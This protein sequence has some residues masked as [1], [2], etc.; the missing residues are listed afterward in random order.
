MYVFVGDYGESADGACVTVDGDGETSMAAAVI[1]AEQPRGRKRVTAA[2]ELA[3]WLIGDAYDAHSSDSETMV[4]SVA[5]HFLIPREGAVNLWS[6][7][8]HD[9]PRRRAIRVAGIYR[10]S[11]TATVNQLKNLGLIEEHDRVALARETP[12]AGDFAA[13]GVPL[14]VDDLVAPRLSPVLTAA[15]VQGYE[16]AKLTRKRALK[17]LR[18]SISDAELR[19][20]DDSPF[21]VID[22]DAGA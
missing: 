6:R 16:E 12:V 19:P 8:P 20:R 3:H 4:K 21:E 17:M 7:F 13:V 1:N 18:G 5:I 14:F 15:I 9:G 10:V 2:Y 11:W 22:G